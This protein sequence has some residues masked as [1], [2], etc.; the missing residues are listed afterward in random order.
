MNSLV[1]ISSMEAVRRVRQ[2]GSSEGDL[3]QWAE[4]G[5]LRSRAQRGQ[6]SDDEEGVERI[7]ELPNTP[8][9]QD[10]EIANRAVVGEPW[11]DIP[12]N[13]WHWINKNIQTSEK[14]WGSGVFS[15]TVY[16]ET[17]LGPKGDSQHIKLL[18]VTFCDEDLKDLLLPVKNAVDQGV[19]PSS[20]MPNDKRYE[21]HAHRAAEIIRDKRLKRSEAFRMA[22]DEVLP[23]TKIDMKSSESA[24]RKTYGLM[25]D[26][27]GLPIKKDQN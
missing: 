4:A 20:A 24:L 18:G 6:F 2:G 3:A 15:T 7:L 16:Y 14:H 13:F 23:P 5:A 25:Y 27:N 22:F 11:P 8:D 21:K 12:K 10:K 19:L 26:P 9:E 1:W 17:E